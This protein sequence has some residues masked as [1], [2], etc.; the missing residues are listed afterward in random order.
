MRTD[1]S[2]FTKMAE[3]TCDIGEVRPH[4]SKSPEVS[5]LIAAEQ[6]KVP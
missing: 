3:D 4:G 5:R 6:N 2:I 1:I